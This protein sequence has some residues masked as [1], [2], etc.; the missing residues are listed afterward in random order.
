M[1]IT[2]GELAL[3]MDMN[4]PAVTK[5]VKALVEKQALTKQ[6]DENDGRIVHLSITDEGLQLLNRARE[7]SFPVIG[8]GFAGLDDGELEHLNNLLLKVKKEIS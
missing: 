3:V 5:A 8:Q 1:K 6:A 2:I 7:A 4:Q